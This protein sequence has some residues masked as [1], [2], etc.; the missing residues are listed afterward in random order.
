MPSAVWDDITEFQD[1][2]LF[3]SAT[4]SRVLICRIGA[5][6]EC[7]VKARTVATGTGAITARIAIPAKYNFHV[8]PTNPPVND[9]TIGMARVGNGTL[10]MNINAGALYNGHR[11]II[12]QGV[13]RN[14]DWSASFKWKTVAHLT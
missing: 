12:G 7:V 11:C 2:D 6:V 10:N 1:P 9:F 5:D 14:T 4:G 3:D 8:S 13:A